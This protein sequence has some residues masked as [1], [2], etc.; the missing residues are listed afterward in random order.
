LLS[1]Q[2]HAEVAA[3][4]CTP[5]ADF[6]SGWFTVRSTGCLTI[7]P[8]SIPQLVKVSETIRYDRT[9]K[10][11]AIVY[12]VMRP[13]V[14]REFVELFETLVS[15]FFVVSMRSSGSQIVECGNNTPDLFA[16]G[17]EF[18]DDSQLVAKTH[19]GNPERGKRSAGGYQ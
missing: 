17:I 9:Q 15:Q 16:G 8:K 5:G 14:F 7:I 1:F 6:G 3:L 12:Q 2:H 19:L 18:S 10:E 11:F 13:V 4:P